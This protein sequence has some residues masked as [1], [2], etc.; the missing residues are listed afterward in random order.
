MAE[1]QLNTVWTNGC[2]DVLHVG[3]IE[4]LR[5]AKT[6]GSYLIVGI[7]SDSR[8]KSL[9]GNDRPFNNQQDRKNFLEA[10]KYVDEVVIFNSEKELEDTV[11]NMNVD[12]IVVGEE[13]KGRN[14]VGSIHADVIF[15]P[16]VG[17]HS[18]SRILK[19][20]DI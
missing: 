5:F 20:V 4:M 1:A 14:V 7:D 9:K 17:N 11:M 18:T 6:K 2:F 3:H 8:V 13:Y 15:F 10:I 12:A 16:R 19:S